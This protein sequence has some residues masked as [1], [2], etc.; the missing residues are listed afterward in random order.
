[1]P[2]PARINDQRAAEAAGRHAGLAAAILADRELLAALTRREQ[3]VVAKRYLEPSA[4]W[5]AIGEQLGMT[6]Y[7]AASAWARAARK[8]GR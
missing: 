6:K 8:A 3:L 7:Q 5:T 1:M 4:S 2:W